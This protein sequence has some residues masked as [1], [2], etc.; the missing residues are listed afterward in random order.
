MPYTPARMNLRPELLALVSALF[1]AAPAASADEAA[2][3]VAPASPLPTAKTADSTFAVD[4]EALVITTGKRTVR[5]HPIAAAIF[6][7]SDGK[8]SIDAIRKG[9]EEASGYPIDEA[10]V[11][12]ALD[13]LADAKLLVARVTPPGAE[14]DLDLVVVADG[15]DVKD[16]VA[17]TTATKEAGTTWLKQR[18]NEAKTKKDSFARHKTESDAKAADPALKTSEQA[19]KKSLAELSSARVKQESAVKAKKASS[20]DAE[21][22]TAKRKLSEASAKSERT[23]RVKQKLKEEEQKTTKMMKKPG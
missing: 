11:F 16:L 5:L 18:D 1:L 6:A 21:K 10:T 22:V 15:T 19:R 2:S 4:G 17:P 8:R 14:S 3:A 7:L 23:V 20:E 9:A 12:A 13:A